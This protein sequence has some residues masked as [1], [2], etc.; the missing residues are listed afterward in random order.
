[1]Y[2][3]YDIFTRESESASAILTVFS[4]LKEFSRSQAVTYTGTL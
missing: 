1:M 2:T 3:N 4:K